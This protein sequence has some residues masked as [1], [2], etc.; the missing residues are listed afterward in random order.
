MFI[1]TDIYLK[2]YKIKFKRIYYHILK[3]ATKSLELYKRYLHILFLRTFG[4]PCTN[5]HLI[6]FFFNLQLIYR[7]RKIEENSRLKREILLIMQ[8]LLQVR[9]THFPSKQIICQNIK[10]ST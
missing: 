6:E 3:Q 5:N 4:T 7:R 1:D 8:S 9:V 2:V 10:V